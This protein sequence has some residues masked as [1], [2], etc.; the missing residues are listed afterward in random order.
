MVR[1]AEI[2]GVW[3][4]AEIIFP[5]IFLQDPRRHDPR[6]A[7]LAELTSAPNMEES[8][9]TKSEWE[10][11]SLSEPP[12]SAV[13][14]SETPSAT[15]S[16]KIKNDKGIFEHASD[17]E[18]NKQTPELKVPDDAKNDA[19]TTKIDV[20]SDFP[21]SPRQV[22][23]NYSLAV[24]AEAEEPDESE[25]A[26]IEELEQ[27]SPTVSSPSVLED[28][29]QELPAVPPYV[30]L[31]KEQER[32]V[33]KLSI[34]R[35]IESYKHLN[36]KECEDMRISLIARLVAQVIAKFFRKIHLEAE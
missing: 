27:H 15:L 36:G 22:D 7:L 35:I 4:Y 13:A 12:P 30:E 20:S 19:A 32:N 24:K 8:V 21:L 5:N 28:T 1:E 10:S 23:E 31:T 3:P 29:I 2:F 34:K 18:T 26:D 11:H 25:M 6:L 16:P 33:Q 14:S 17:Y 9:A